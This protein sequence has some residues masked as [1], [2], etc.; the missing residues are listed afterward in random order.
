MKIPSV[1]DIAQVY[2]DNLKLY[3]KVAIMMARWVATVRGTLVVEKIE[4]PKF[5]QGFLHYDI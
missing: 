5:K 3:P 2:R 4:T 1:G